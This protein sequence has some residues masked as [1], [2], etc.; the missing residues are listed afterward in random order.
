MINLRTFSWIVLVTI[1]FIH[2][3]YAQDN[4][5]I[6]AAFQRALLNGTRTL[7]GMP[8]TNYWQNTANY[9]LDITFQPYNRLLTGKMEVTYHNNSPDTLRQIWFKLY[10]NIYKNGVWRKSKIARKD[11]NEGVALDRV[12]QNGTTV[13]PEQI[14][15]D[16][17]NMQ[18]DVP[19]VLPGATIRFQINYHYTLNAGSHLRTGKVDDGAYFIAYFFPRIAVYDDIDGW[20]TYPYSG[21]EEFY[22]DFCNFNVTIKVP[23]DYIVWATGDLINRNKIFDKKLLRRLDTAEKSDTTLTVHQVDTL[24]SKSKFKPN[25]QHTFAFVADSVVDFAFAMSNHYLWKSTS[26]IVDS[27]SQRRT[28]VDAVYNPLHHDYAAVIDFARKTVH[29]IST[30]FPAWPF[31]YPHITVFDGLDQM[32]YPMMANDN[33]TKTREDAITLTNHE[34]FHTIFP[35]YMGINET[36]YGWMDE[37]W[38]TIGEW[39]L[40]KLIDSTYTDDYGVAATAIASGGKDDTPIMTLTP[41]LKGAA[42]FTNS[43]PKPA[44]GYLF[45]EEYLGDTL[46]RKALHHYIHTWHGKHPQPMD[47]FNA[48]NAGSGKDLNW[49][50]KRWFFDDGVLDLAISHVTRIA[51]AYKVYIRNKSKKPLPVHLTIYYRDGSAQKINHSIGLWKTDQETIEIPIITDK[52]IKKIILGDTYIPDHYLKDNRFIVNEP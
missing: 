33:P 45:V 3:G 25:A 40:S 41:N 22:N 49:F 7:T 50:W 2:N 15:I 27:S 20:N 51:G 1:C 16:G 31:P 17:T 34:I 8:G 6:D 42:T 47:F 35:F 44:L 36:K 23:K 43:Y 11:L 37:G 12:K 26:L 19:D 32:E 46:F 52:R 10:P 30:V 38:A 48:M 4:L 28:R 39:K 5:P 18:L 9:K 13:K 29:G 21:E 24:G 14:H